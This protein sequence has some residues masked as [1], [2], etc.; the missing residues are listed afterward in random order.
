M[1]RFAGLLVALILMMVSVASAD[2]VQSHYLFGYVIEASSSSFEIITDDESIY[3]FSIDQSTSIATSSD[4]LLDQA[5]MVMYIG[6][7]NL[8]ARSQNVQVAEITT[9]NLIHG[10]IED[11]TSS[12]VSVR[13]MDDQGNP[14]S[15]YLF[16]RENADIVVGEDGIVIG[17]EVEVSF[18][19]TLSQ[20]VPDQ[21]QNFPY[22]HITVYGQVEDEFE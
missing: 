8:N 12:T 20:L 6:D 5:V 7:L 17:D 10:R 14:G 3:Q 2:M 1:K 19:E 4:R 15:L 16:D 21:V 9:L 11:G 22:V 18:R 13:V